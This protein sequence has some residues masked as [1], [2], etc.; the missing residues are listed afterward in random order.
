VPLGEDCLFGIIEGPR[1]QID[2][3]L[4]VGSLSFPQGLRVLE[5]NGQL[6]PLLG[7]M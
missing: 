3:P 5:F 6:Y 2:L 1:D 7:E 4:F